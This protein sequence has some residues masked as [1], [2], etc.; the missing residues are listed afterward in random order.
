M[1]PARTGTAIKLKATDPATGRPLWSVRYWGPDN[2]RHRDPAHYRSETAARSA[3]SRIMGKI[4]DGTWTDPDAPNAAMTVAQ[5]AE[6]YMEL[7][8]KR[9]PRTGRTLGEY[10]AMLARFI[11][12]EFG[13]RLVADVTPA[14]V[15][16]WYARLCPDTPTQR[17]RVYGLLAG[18]YRYAER[19][20]LVPKS[21]CRQR[22]AA[23]VDPVRTPY[24]PSEV[25]LGI[26]IDAMPDPL[27]LA[28][29]LGANLGLRAGE[30]LALQRQDIDLAHNVIHVRHGLTRYGGANHVGGPKTRAATRDEHVTPDT[31]QWLAE[32]ID[33][34]VAPHDDAP[35]FAN[36]NGGHLSY[37][38]LNS[39]WLRARGRAG[40]PE[41]QIHDL[42]RLTATDLLDHGAPLRVVQ[43][44]LGHEQPTMSL[45]YAQSRAGKRA[46]VMAAKPFRGGAPL[47]AEHAA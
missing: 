17:A 13:K 10:R 40:A 15:A 35:L 8:T 45:H 34:F 3:L 24:L 27:K 20:D 18:M 6:T 41:C 12:P 31:A 33:L 43:D 1:P 14:H 11:L 46:E 21:P 47:Y 2:R 19:I 39:A 4:A 25:E 7:P 36:R 38:T 16:T 29:V 30:L 26:I 37:S 23:H 5:L 28:V 42:R 32:H 44:I 22:G 9:G